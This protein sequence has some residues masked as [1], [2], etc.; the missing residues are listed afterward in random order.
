MNRKK[1][2]LALVIAAIA[3]LAILT[4]ASP[5]WQLYRMRSAVEARDPQK[6]AQFVD[7]PALRESVKLLLMQRLGAGSALSEAQSNPFAAFGKA[8]A[9]AVIDPVVDAAV[10]PAGVALMLERGDV[11][12]R[13]ER[14]APPDASPDAGQAHEPA[15]EKVNYDLSYAGWD[16]VTVTKADGSGAVFIL[17]RHGLWGWKLSGVALPPE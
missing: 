3:G 5:H 11:K 10:S 14:G 7:F 16:R 8:M 12:L 2:I 17:R 13:S 1:V 6:L 9:L 4:Y 15:R